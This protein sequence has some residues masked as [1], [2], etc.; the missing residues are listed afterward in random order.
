MSDDRPNTG[1]IAVDT[2][3]EQTGDEHERREDVPAAAERPEDAPITAERREDGSTTAEQDE[4]LE[5][6]LGTDD[7]GGFRERWQSI[8]VSF[9]DEPRRAVEDADSLV[10]ELMQRLAQT[11]HDERETLESQWSRGDDVSTE[12]LRVGLKRYRSFFERL[13]AT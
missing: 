7:A 11:F 13:L 3:D 4:P 2:K 10:A 8:Q 9:V 1:D 12:D 5:P 6:L